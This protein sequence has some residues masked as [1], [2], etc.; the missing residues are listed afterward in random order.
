MDGSR[1]VEKHKLK[2]KSYFCYC[3]PLKSEGKEKN[4]LLCFCFSGHLWK[5]ECHTYYR[6]TFVYRNGESSIRPVKGALFCD[7]WGPTGALFW[8]TLFACIYLFSLSRTHTSCKW[9]LLFLL[10][11]SFVLFF[12]SRRISW[13]STRPL[14]P[15][16]LPKN[17][18]RFSSYERPEWKS[19]WG[20]KR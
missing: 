4:W 17:Q 8:K 9:N 18:F 12:P 10:L 13:M 11:P 2:L 6:L 14:L 5:K 3:R 20:G 16:Q 7:E 1:I 19:Y 15:H